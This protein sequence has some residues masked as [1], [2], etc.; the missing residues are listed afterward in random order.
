M[1]EALLVVGGWIVGYLSSSFVQRRGLDRTR[2]GNLYA[3]LGEVRT[4]NHANDRVHRARE[5]RS[6]SNFLGR[7][8][9]QHTEHVISV[10]EAMAAIEH[11]KPQGPQ[12][13]KEADDAKAALSTQADD[14]LNN[15]LRELK[16]IGR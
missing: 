13:R 7:R 5:I 12:E 3:L 16:R 1:L 8:I 6:H 11:S 9:S 14:G 10:W 15:L 2:A 4:L